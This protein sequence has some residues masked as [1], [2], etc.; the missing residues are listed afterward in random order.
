MQIQQKNWLIVVLCVITSCLYGQ[1]TATVSGSFK[2]TK[3]GDWIYVEFQDKMDSV[4]V[5]NG[6]F[7]TKVNCQ[8]QWD[9]YWLRGKRG[10]RYTCPLFLKEGSIIEFDIDSS[11][12][13]FQLSG[14]E[15][16][17]EQNQFYSVWAEKLETY[18]ALEGQ[19]SSAKDSATVI[20]PGEQLRIAKEQYFHFPEKWIESHSSSPFS[21]AIVKLYAFKHANKKADTLAERLFDLLTPSATENNNV[22]VALRQSFSLFNDKY[23]AVP[24]GKKSPAFNLRDLLGKAIR[25]SDFKGNYLLIDFWASWCVPCRENNPMLRA[26]FQKYKN[27]NIRVLSISVDEDANDWRQ[28]VAKD[29]LD[30]Q[31]GSDLLGVS[32]GIGNVFGLISIP[33]YFIIDPKGVVV[34]KPGIDKLDAALSSIFISN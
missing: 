19:I 26:I 23:T 2:N 15:N 27:Q 31:Q 14:D 7:N 33:Q 9:I 4:Q 6:R 22:A 12:T 32:A 13:R 29:K 20:I 28:A 34:A 17:N 5:V 24:V 30:W 18:K 10:S 8:K 21:C 11:L 3:D 16:A 1:H 25:S